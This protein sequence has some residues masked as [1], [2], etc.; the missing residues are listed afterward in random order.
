MTKEEL[1]VIALVQSDLNYKDWVVADKWDE[2]QK[3]ARELVG[4]GVL[5]IDYSKDCRLRYIPESE[6]FNVDDFRK[7][8]LKA[9]SGRVG[10]ASTKEEVVKLL[11]QVMKEHD[12]T[13]QQC[14]KAAKIYVD[15]TDSRYLMKCNNFILNDKGES[16][17]ASIASDDS[18][19]ESQI[20]WL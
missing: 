18:I 8:W 5:E 4:Q 16:H 7:Y 11:K 12:I 9:Y 15:S 3:I 20:N 13:F 10:Y 6:K 2:L 19:K 1:F 14:C 17:L